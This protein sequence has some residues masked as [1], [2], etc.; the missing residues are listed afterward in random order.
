MVCA[1]GTSFWM[2]LIAGSFLAYGK[3]NQAS[4]Q[5][6]AHLHSG[7]CTCSLTDVSGNVSGQW[8]FL[9]RLKI[10]AMAFWQI[11]KFHKSNLESD[12]SSPPGTKVSKTGRKND[13]IFKCKT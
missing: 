11:Q 2:H 3:L 9:Y 5:P 7:G 10:I 6:K 8:F 1:S 4:T 12:L 13:D